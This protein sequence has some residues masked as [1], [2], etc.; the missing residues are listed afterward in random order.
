MRRKVVI[1]GGYGTF[2]SFISEELS[3][4]ADVVVAGRNQAKGQKFAESLG[5]EFSLCDARDNA[6]LRAAIKGANIVI[7]ASGPFF[8]NDY[9]IPR[10][11][12]EEN[13]HYIDLADNRAYVVNFHKLHDLAQDRQV[14]ACTGASTAPAVTYALICELQRELTDIHSIQIY[15]SAGNKNKAGPS[16][17]ESILSYAGAPVHIWDDGQWKRIM[18]WDL[19]EHFRFP[20]PVGKRLVQVCDIPDL[21]LFPQLFE[22]D[23]VIFRAGLELPIFN[24]GLSLLAQLKKQFPQIKLPALVKPLI[25]ISS[26]F[27]N[28]GSYAGSVLVK[29]D[30]KKGQSKTLALV[31]SHNGPRIPTA[32][33][34]LLTRKIL[35][36]GPPNP[37][38]FPCIGFIST[39]DFV[40]YLEP[41]GIKLIPG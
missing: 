20:N 12:L 9:G 23:G 35:Q 31:T 19:R 15:L 33:A 5:A 21:E 6:S 40:N 14:F 41:F 24:I 34:V 28:F 7:N 18:G 29:V 16:T 3:H 4:S 10:A 26:L 2:G 8:P 30:N 11:C 38:A 36:N 37:G 39:N 27:K 22:V 25:G 17:F 32:P 1:L 13:C